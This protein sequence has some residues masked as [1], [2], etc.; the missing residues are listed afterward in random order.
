MKK[1]LL[2]GLLAC[3]VLIVGGAAKF[4]KGRTARASDSHSLP[5][6]VQGCKDA[7]NAMKSGKG[8][9][10]VHNISYGYQDDTRKTL[11]TEETYTVAFDG[12]KYRISGE[13]L[14]IKNELAVGEYPILPGTKLDVNIAF[15]G[16]SLMSYES[17]LRTGRI[18]PSTIPEMA[19][20]QN[21]KMVNSVLVIPPGGR[22]GRG[23]TGQG[24][25]RIDLYPSLPVDEA[26]KG[27]RIARRES[28]NGHGCV[29]VERVIEG[30]GL[31]LTREFWVDPDRGFTVPRV[32]EWAEGG[33]VHNRV[34]TFEANA[35][36]RD[37]GNGVWGPA[38]YT[39]EQNQPDG[40]GGIRPD[41]RYETTY[42]PDFR[43]NVPVTA[44]DLTIKLPPGVLMQVVD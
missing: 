1:N 25:Q 2:I 35:E 3:C 30:K 13:Q 7:V 17:R 14:Y 28:L 44:E 16:E 19:S 23:G 12:P 24:V 36:L 4:W 34:I 29:V 9:V 39:Y 42:E 8:T 40:N 37:Y 43:L 5:E 18:G 22:V 11:E 26:Y 20:L 38:K 32:R 21:S 33:P 6:L 31:T 27:L 15:D 41:Y 10:K